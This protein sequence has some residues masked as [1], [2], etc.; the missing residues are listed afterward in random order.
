[1]TRSITEP[2]VSP[3]GRTSI[4]SVSYTNTGNSYDVAIGGTPFYLAA[5]K[6]Y[7]YKRETAPY[8]R[9]QID[10]TKEPG[11]QSLLGWWLRSQSSFHLGAGVKYQEPV[12][13]DQVA[14]RYWK[15]AGVNPWNVGKVELLNTMVANG[16]TASGAPLVVGGQDANGV[17]VAIVAVGSALY[18]VLA[19][20]TYTSLT[21]GGATT[22][23]AVAES[24][25]NY[26]VSTT[27]DVYSGPLTGGSAG[28]SVFTYPSA[29]TTVAMSWV[30]QRL[31]VGAGAKIWQII[32]GGGA[33]AAALYTHPV[34]GWR[35]S[36][37]ADGPNCIYLAGYAGMSSSIFRLS[38]DTAGALP[39]LT[40][41]VTAADLPGGEYITGLATYVGK[42]I[43]IGTN[44][45]IRVGTIDTTGYYTAGQVTYG[46]LSVITNGYDNTY[47][48]TIAGSNVTSFAFDDKFVYANVTNMIDNGDG[49]LSSGLICIDLSRELGSGL[50]AWATDARTMTTAAVTGVA[51]VG[52][53]GKKIMVGA[54][55][56][57]VE[58]GNKVP[59]GYLE[60]GQIRY[61][62]LEDKHF[63]LLKPRIQ[64]PMSGTIEAAGVSI[65][66]TVRPIVVINDAIDPSDDITTGSNTP[67]ESMAFRFTL[68]RSATAITTGPT[69]NGY[70]LKAL[71]AVKRARLLSLPLINFD[72]EE[73]RNNV[74][75]GYTGRA[76]VRILA[77]E[78]I[79]S[80]GDVIT[81]QDFTLG[82]QVQAVIESV[83]FV[84]T[85]PPTRAFS[86]FGG[87][88]YVTARTV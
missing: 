70:Q 84:R 65:D 46:P 6:E 2:I 15:S 59:S 83:Q 74:M 18:R 3:V 67:V 40:N 33:P 82:E 55:G 69:L 73:D 43:A 28:T 50:M 88:L 25:T 77:L 32:P 34:T 10:Q 86:G 12:H 39:T 9:Q 64:R 56:I 58:S 30:K 53:S 66:G 11:E 5:T 44:R 14:F 21:W 23:L 36:A 52:A 41:A 60:T 81:V 13:G 57:Y 1:M 62:T 38:L 26:Y 17:D 78:D 76:G 37:V 31:I 54:D 29:V 8:R 79:E 72:W 20:G 4:S 27:T 16:I 71:P 80:I 63:K 87:I 22:I 49:T 47:T 61:L 51:F 19:N 48:R 24:G 68:N 45:G 85:S 7:P 75:D 35:W 42:F